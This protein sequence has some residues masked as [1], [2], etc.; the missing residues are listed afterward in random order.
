[1]RLD[2]YVYGVL[3]AAGLGTAYWASLP[4]PS[5]DDEK[6]SILSIE[7]KSVTQV[8]YKTAT[9][10]LTAVKRPSDGRFWVTVTKTELPME[11]PHQPKD[12]KAPPP[13]P[14]T[15][16]ERFLANEKWT[17]VLKNLNPLY[18]DRVLDKVDDKQLADY[19]LK[20]SKDSWTVTSAGAKDFSLILGKRSY[21][22]RSRFAQQPDTKGRVLII[23]GED[24][25]ALERAS[26]RLYERRLT[27]VDLAE[28]TKADI[29][30]GAKTKATQHTQR[31]KDRVL[32]WTDAVEG[33]KS[34]G[35]LD[36][37]MDKVS[38]LRLTEYA[39]TEEEASL[40]A[41]K[42]FLTVAL[43]K[44]GKVVDHLVFKK[45]G[46]DKP[47]YWA[48]SD[49]LQTYVKVLNNRVEPMEK[50]AAGLVADEAEAKKGP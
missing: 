30:V 4:A 48:T 45:V 15:T 2:I 31:G 14:K 1:M 19:G 42:P 24:L 29:T 44:D 18:V 13:T 33:A 43:T 16:T 32:L 34:N 17:D 41:P 39:T 38:K 3:L 40:Q 47:I 27:D 12:P 37:F 25:E 28:V 5:G 20:D 50:D 11:N 10:T 9:S 22:S 46:T 49:F 26:A 23:D 8:A 21:G 35:S 6:V 36:S 7:P